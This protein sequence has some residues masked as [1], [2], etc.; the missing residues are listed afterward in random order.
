MP[1]TKSATKKV[2]RP[3][4]G[5]RSNDQY[6]QTTLLLRRDTLDD[7]FRALVSEGRRIEL[8]TLVQQLLEKWLAR[9]GK[10]PKP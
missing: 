4:T 5:K 7:T 9:G 10:I 2:G 1:P 6:R 8:S 3:A